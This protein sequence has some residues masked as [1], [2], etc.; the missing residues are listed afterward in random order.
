MSEEIGR[1]YTWVS[2]C[3]K[4]VDEFLNLTAPFLL[5]EPEINPQLQW[6]LKQ[7]AISCN[8]TSESALLLISYERLWDAEVL[9][10]SVLE[11][12][13]KYAFLCIG[14]DAERDE[15]VKEYWEDLPEITR[16]KRHRRA[17]EILDMVDNPSA[18]E[19]RSL[20]D[21]LVDSAE[22]DSLRVKYPRSLRQKLEQKW[23]FNEI[24]RELQNSG[25]AGFE[26]LVGLTYTYGISS[27]IIHQD[28]DAIGIIWDRRRREIERRTAI[29]L[30][31]GA[32]EISD[33]LSMAFFRALVTYKMHN[34]D[35]KPV[36]ALY[37]SYQGLHKEL[38]SAIKE[39][40][41]IE[42]K[43]S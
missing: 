6:V 11:G 36:I 12:T 27:H 33:L 31:H 28:G 26:M 39:W 9:V 34:T 21:L 22:L 10:R 24:I 38:N 2:G 7:L 35:T 14:S 18:V 43:Q 37:D 16:M 5:L 32:R 20:K 29:E 1:F 8:Q 4:A 17:S 30:A 23:S 15:K 25:V 42:Y 40:G 3:S 13:L 41:R 19:W